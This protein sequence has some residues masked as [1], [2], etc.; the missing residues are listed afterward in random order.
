MGEPMSREIEYFARFARSWALE[1]EPGRPVAGGVAEQRDE[2]EGR[3]DH[4][5]RLLGE[6]DE[7][8]AEVS[9]AVRLGP[10]A[11]RDLHEERAGDVERARDQEA[12]PG[13][14]RQGAEE[15]QVGQPQ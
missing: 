7:R 12:A 13:V 3:A 4:L 5:E 2:E 11:E 8:V 14:G 15:P 6:V 9:V 1:V 10:Q